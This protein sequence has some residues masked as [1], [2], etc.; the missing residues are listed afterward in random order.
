MTIFPCESSFATSTY[1]NSSD[2]VHGLPQLLQ[3]CSKFL[4]QSFDFFRHDSFPQISGNPPM[5]TFVKKIF[6]SFI[7]N[8]NEVCKE[9]YILDVILL[10]IVTRLNSVY[11][12]SKNMFWF[13]SVLMLSVPLFH[14]ILGIM[15]Y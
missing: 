5:L 15:T 6:F 14:V 3:L 2:F 4:E 10:Y 7:M 8:L 9:R 13:L 11:I 1:C 12:Y